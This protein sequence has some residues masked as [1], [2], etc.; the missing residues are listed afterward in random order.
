M[1]IFF[2]L[3]QMS[4]NFGTACD[5]DATCGVDIRGLPNKV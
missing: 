5:Y 3:S 4:K 1:Y 2:F